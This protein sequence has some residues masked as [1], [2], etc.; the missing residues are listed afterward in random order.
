V[1]YGQFELLFS[2]AVDI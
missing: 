1:R 2:D